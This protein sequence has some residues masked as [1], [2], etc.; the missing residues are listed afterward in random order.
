MTVIGCLTDGEI[1]DA[2]DLLKS[3]KRAVACHSA[4]A[5]TSARVRTLVFGIGMIT[6]AFSSKVKHK[7]QSCKQPSGRLLASK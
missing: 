6:P 1:A 3:N 2:K 5:Q 4:T 7:Q